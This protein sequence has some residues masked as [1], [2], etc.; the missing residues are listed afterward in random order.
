VLAREG[1]YVNDAADPGGE[2][3]MGIS[4]RAYPAV[5]ILNLTR[6]QAG[7]IYHRDYWL[8]CACDTLDQGAALALFDTAVNVGVTRALAMWQAASN[9][10]EEF[11]W[12]RLAYYSTLVHLARFLPSWLKRVLL[13]RRTIHAQGGT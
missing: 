5:D 8:A 3:N 12:A 4:K 6:E 1:G 10:V 11:L 2:T 7:D 13:L 9:D